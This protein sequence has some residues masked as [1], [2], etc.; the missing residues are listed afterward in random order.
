MPSEQEWQDKVRG[1][2]DEHV[3][4]HDVQL[5]VRVHADPSLPFDAF[6]EQEFGGWVHD[7]VDVTV[8]SSAGPVMPG[9]AESEWTVG[10]N[11]EL[12]IDLL[13]VRR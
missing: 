5:A 8:A 10:D 2:L 13:L 9:T 1:V 11:G 6:D 4:R 7:W 12:R 3:D